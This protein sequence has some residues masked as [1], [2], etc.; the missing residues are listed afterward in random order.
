MKADEKFTP[1]IGA[2]SQ[3]SISLPR[4]MN[5]IARY[6]YLTS[7]LSIIPSLCFNRTH[8]YNRSTPH[9]T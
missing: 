4:A 1:Y 3:V 8:R 9:V 7:A 6:Q 2:V 5:V